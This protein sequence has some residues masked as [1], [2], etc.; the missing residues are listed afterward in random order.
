MRTLDFWEAALGKLRD[1]QS[2]FVGLVADHTRHSPG[3]R[4][5]RLMLDTHREIMGTIGGGVMEA[6]LLEE[7]NAAL[8]APDAFSPQATTLFHQKQARGKESGLICAG[9][10]TNVSALMRPD[11]A[12]L[13]ERVVR[14]LRADEPGLLTLHDTGQWELVDQQSVRALA[15]VRLVQCDEG[16]WLYE[17]Q[18]LAQDRVA[19]FGA[20]HCGQ[21]LTQMMSQLGYVVTLVDVREDVWTLGQSDGATYTII[22]KDYAQSAARISH[23][24]LTPVVVMTADFPS[25]TQALIGA[26]NEPF[27][28]IGL[29]GAPAKLRAIQKALAERGFDETQRAR[30]TAPVGLAIGSST[31]AEIAVSVAAQL[32]QLRPKLFPARAPSPFPHRQE[33]L[34]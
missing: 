23:P 1:G 18:L 28:F 15:P 11:H 21:A 5:A 10:Q 19:I 24:A 14:R 34:S 4:G 13:L 30:L 6:R 2:I 9:S 26:L 7:G 17:E 27:P 29:M 31:P 3:T 25:D 12:P 16:Q 22:A 20:G 8:D 32:I 33:A